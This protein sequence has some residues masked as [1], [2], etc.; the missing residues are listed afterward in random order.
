M[1]MQTSAFVLPEDL[2]ELAGQLSAS[3]VNDMRGVG[4][5]VVATV[6]GFAIASA[7]DSTNDAHRIAAMASSICAIGSVV[8]L[9]AGLGNC[10]SVTI[11]SDLGFVVV[12]ALQ[13]PDLE[14]VISVIADNDAILAHVLIKLKSMVAQLL[15]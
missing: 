8:G 9:E 1:T 12:Q 7:F 5:V 11:N 15:A 3:F 10:R 2:A 6:D 13:R 4:T 14:L